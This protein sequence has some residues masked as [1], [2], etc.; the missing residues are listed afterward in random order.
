MSP[1]KVSIVIP[2]YNV[3]NYLAACLESAARQDYDNFEIIAIDD[4]S[5]DASPSILEDFCA[6]HENMILERIDNQGVSV[7]RNTGL[8]IATGDYIL[9]LDSDDFLER[10]AVSTCME[11]F[12]TQQADVVFFAANVFFDG[13]DEGLKKSFRGER[14]ASL[15]GTCIPAHTFFSRSIK[16]KSYLVP[17]YLYMYRRKEFEDL[18][19]PRR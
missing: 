15:H 6:R 9:F 17:P 3:E 11:I 16:L 13:V 4:G 18:R 1:E 5:T 12:R 19:F 10:H 2:V 14:V 8:E 7:A